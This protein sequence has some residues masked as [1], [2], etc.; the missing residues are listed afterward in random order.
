MWVKICGNT[1]LDDCQ[2][3]V[4]LGVDALGFIFAHGKRL[5]TA[6]HVRGITSQLPSH[7][8]T[9]GVFTQ[10]DPDFIANTAVVAGIY[11]VQLHGAFDPVLASV[12]RA[13]FPKGEAPRLLQVVHWDVDAPAME[14]QQWLSG[15]LAVLANSGVVDAVLVDSHTRQGSGGTGVTFDWG[16]AAP[17]VRNAKLPVIAAGGLRP[18]NVGDAVRALQPWGVDVSSGVE[19]APGMKDHE[20]IEAFVQAARQR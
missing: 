14:Q 11:G 10:D 2:R 20:K 4:E 3:A 18:E 15:Q 7:V 12:L 19:S 17:V 9:Y 8:A 13:R 16:A 1:R 5:V 6:E